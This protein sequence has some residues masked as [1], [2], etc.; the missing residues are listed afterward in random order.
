M[1]GKNLLPAAGKSAKRAQ[2]G[3]TLIE[4]LVVIAIIAILA[5]ILFPVFARARENARRA[6]CQSNLKQAGL[7]FMQYSQDYD[8][9]MPIT[10]GGATGWDTSIAPYLGI[11]VGIDK[12]PLLLN[13]PSDTITRVG[14]SAVVNPLPR[15][16]GMA[17]PARTSGG[18]NPLVHGIGGWYANNGALSSCDTPGNVAGCL[19]LAIIPKPAETLLLVENPTTGNFFGSSSGIFA[20]SAD[21]QRVSSLQPIHLEGWNYL[22]ADGHVKWLRP[23]KTVGTG[24]VAASRGMWTI[25][26]ND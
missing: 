11:K 19:A 24:T 4:L 5:A 18:A 21:A 16:Y 15:T 7:A 2:S 9:K 14:T 25:D 26:E 1:S 8:E 13:C 6:S 17:M 20:V 10:Y 23:E 22:F 12:A 3:F